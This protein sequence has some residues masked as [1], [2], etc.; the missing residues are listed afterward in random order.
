MVSE[1][2]QQYLTDFYLWLTN[3][4]EQIENPRLHRHLYHFL[5]DKF[6]EQTTHTVCLCMDRVA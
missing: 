2:I 4:T 1:L 3:H 5:W 6:E